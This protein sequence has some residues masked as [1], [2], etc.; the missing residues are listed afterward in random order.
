MGVGERMVG[1]REGVTTKGL[2]ADV[3]ISMS[4]QAE[5]KNESTV[6]VTISHFICVSWVGIILQSFCIYN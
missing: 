2:G 4:K 6:S 3:T 5:S 1:G